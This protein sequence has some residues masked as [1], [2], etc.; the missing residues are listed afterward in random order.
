MWRVL[1]QRLSLLLVTGCKVDADSISAVL[2]LDDV[3]YP[4]LDLDIPMLIAS[5]AVAA[6]ERAQVRLYVRLEISLVSW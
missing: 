4:A 1:T 3:V 6:V 5:R 2:S